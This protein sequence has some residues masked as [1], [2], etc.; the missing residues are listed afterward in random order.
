MT[1]YQKVRFFNE[2][3]NYRLKQKKLH[4]KWIKDTIIH[5]K[6]I[7]GNINF[8]FCKDAYLKHLN[9]KYLN[10]NYLTDVISFD[11]SEERIIQGEIFISLDRVKEN[12]KIYGE[13]IK[14]E[15]DRIMIH[16]VLHLIGYKDK[17]L[18][19]REIMREKEEFYLSLRY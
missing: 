5:E 2:G 11:N 18:K 17:T 4:K 7:P 12:S 13:S 6:K 10:R 16:G 8:I 3:I 19:D 14:N 15:L 1:L 9:K